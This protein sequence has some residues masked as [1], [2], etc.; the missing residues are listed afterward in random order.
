[1]NELEK[2]VLKN[3][4]SKT[5]N[6]LSK[7]FSNKLDNKI[8]STLSNMICLH[9]HTSKQEVP[10]EKIIKKLNLEIGDLI[11]PTYDFSITLN[12]FIQAISLDENI[13]HIGNKNEQIE[14]SIISELTQ[15]LNQ[16]DENFDDYHTFISSII[17]DS[18]NKD[19]VN[20]LQTN[21][22]K[23]F[24]IFKDAI[25][26]Q[27]EEKNRNNELIIQVINQ[28]ITKENSLKEKKNSFST[29]LSLGVGGAIAVGCALTLGIFAPVALIPAT[30]LGLKFSSNQIH[31]ISSS[32]LDI[33]SAL[34]S[35]NKDILATVSTKNHNIQKTNNIDISQEIISQ[36][37]K[38][39]YGKI[40]AP[41]K[42]KKSHSEDVKK[43]AEM[44]KGKIPE[45]DY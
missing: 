24:K 36:A 21:K 44:I 1:M 16:K 25:K 34:T 29:L 26:I 4:I 11:F 41:I 19:I 17:K 39:G 9:Y 7:N 23:F 6:E 3:S 15:D 32:A 35:N 2:T 22:R 27:N 10:T 18:N 38:I 37:Q 42:E 5:M 28:L 40:N 8:I 13:N 14:T 43:A 31:K 45:I 33:M 20:Y 12:L 30:Y